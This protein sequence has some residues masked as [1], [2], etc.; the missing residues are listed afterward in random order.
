MLTDMQLRGGIRSSEYVM[1]YQ[2]RQR[3]RFSLLRRYSFTF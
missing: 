1:A 3:C 2:G